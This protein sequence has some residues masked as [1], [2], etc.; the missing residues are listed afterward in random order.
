MS[1]V[2]RIEK[3]EDFTKLEKDAKI[4]LV[5]L[6]S[7]HDFLMLE[8]TIVTDYATFIWIA[9]TYDIENI[10]RKE[11]E[12]RG[13]SDSSNDSVVRGI[14]NS[15]IKTLYNSFLKGGYIEGRRW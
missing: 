8:A 11:M 9:T 4:K 5:K 10:V 1:S 6:Y 3:L 7:G 13:D 15:R 2:F 14:S 12:D